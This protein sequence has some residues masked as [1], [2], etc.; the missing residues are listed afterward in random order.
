MLGFAVGR[1]GIGRTIIQD[2]IQIQIQ[3]QVHIRVTIKPKTGKNREKL[4]EK[5]PTGLGWG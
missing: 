4:D 5:N 2:Q 1:W 3:D